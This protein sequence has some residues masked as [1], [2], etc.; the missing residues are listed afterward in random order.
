M[1]PPDVRGD[2]GQALVAVLLIVMAARRASSGLRCQRA[3]DQP[4]ALKQQALLPPATIV[5]RQLINAAFEG[6]NRRCQLARRGKI[7]SRRTASR[8]GWVMSSA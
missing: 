3:A 6:L 1:R 5:R 7:S 4:G 8:C 2:P